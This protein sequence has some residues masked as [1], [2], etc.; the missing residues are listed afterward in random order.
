VGEVQRAWYR[1]N[2]EKHKARNKLWRDNN[3]EK[4]AAI[5]RKT[6]LKAEYGITPEQYNTMFDEQLG[7]CAICGRHQTMFKR[8]LDVDH[9]HTTGKIRKLLCVQCNTD[10]GVYENR[11]EEF[12]HYLTIVGVCK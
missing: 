9:N 2:K 8:H 5:R 1:N 3:P 12:E 7:C 6:R 10:L 4:M 11:K